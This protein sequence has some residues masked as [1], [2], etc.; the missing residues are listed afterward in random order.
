MEEIEN[1]DRSF[2]AGVRSVVLLNAMYPKSCDIDLL[3]WLDHLVVYTEEIGGPTNL[4][5]SVPQKNAEL[6]VRRDVVTSGVAIMRNL[7]L[8]VPLVNEFGIS[9]ISND[10]AFNF[11]EL[12]QSDYANKLI[13]RSK[14]IVDQYIPKGRASI[15]E[16]IKI[17][18]ESWNIYESENG[19]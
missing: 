2:E 15:E 9:Y 14:W 11:V 17:K 4:H 3:I 7:N 1:F 19:K 5:P 12:L 16:Q 18:T 8:I 6:I 13:A 10:I